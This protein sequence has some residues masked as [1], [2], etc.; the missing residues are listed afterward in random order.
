MAADREPPYPMLAG[1]LQTTHDRLGRTLSMIRENGGPEEIDEC[2][3][4]AL[5]A[6][7]AALAIANG[8]DEV[9]QEARR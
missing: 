1:R 7:D 4:D 6:T 2:V 3:T 8:D 9:L 5:A